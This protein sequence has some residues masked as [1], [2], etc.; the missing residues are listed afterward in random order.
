MG[1]GK[2]I[3][4]VL[5]AP[6]ETRNLKYEV[7]NTNS[8]F[9]QDFEIITDGSPGMFPDWQKGEYQGGMGIPAAWRLA[10][11][12]ANQLGRTPWHSFRAVA[13]KPPEKIEPQPTLLAYPAGSEEPAL[14][15]W[16]SA[17]LDRMWHGNAIGIIAARSPLGYP[18][19]AL[20]VGA[21]SVVV[22]RFG[23]D[24]VTGYNPPPPG[25]RPGE[26]GYLI[27]GRWYHADE[28][29][30]WCG[31]KKPGQLRGMGVLENHFQALSRSQALDSAASAVSSAGVPTGLLESLNPDLTQAEA[32]KLKAAW[33]AAQRTR[34]V[35]VLNPSTHFTPIAWNP[36]ETQLLESRQYSITDWA[37]IFG[38]P[39]SYAGGQNASRVYANIVDQGMD[40]LRYG[41]VGDM[42]AEFEALM[43][44]LLPRGQYVK[45]N[46]DHLLRADTKG[47]YEA[48]AIALAAKFLTADEVRELEEKPPLTDEQKKAI[49]EAA[50]PPPAPGQGAAGPQPARPTAASNSA[51]S[52]TA[53]PR[54][55]AVR[56]VGLVG[57]LL[58]AREWDLALAVMEEVRDFR[59][60]QVRTVD[61]T[62]W[63]LRGYPEFNQH[64]PRWPR[65]T[66]KH[67]G[68]WTDSPGGR[69]PFGAKGAG[70][71][72]KGQWTSWENGV[73]SFGGGTTNEAEITATGK[74]VLKTK[75]MSGTKK[76]KAEAEFDA[77]VDEMDANPV[78]AAAK[79][80]K[81]QTVAEAD[82]AFDA[83]T[84]AEKAAA[85][86]ELDDFLADIQAAVD[87][88]TAPDTNTVPKDQAEV[89]AIAASLDVPKP[90]YSKT[91]DWDGDQWAAYWQASVEGDSIS[92]AVKAANAAGGSQAGQFAPAA[93]PLATV[94]PNAS[95]VA[96]PAQ[97]AADPPPVPDLKPKAAPGTPWMESQW[98]DFFTDDGEGPPMLPDF[99]PDGKAQLDLIADQLGVQPPPMGVGSKS[100]SGEQWQTYWKESTYGLKPQ[101]AAAKA[102]GAA[103]AP[104]VGKLDAAPNDPATAKA[105]IDAL[106]AE[107]GKGPGGAPLGDG[108]LPGASPNLLGANAP[109]VSLG[110]GS[111]LDTGQKFG[112]FAVGGPLV[113]I[114]PTPYGSPSSKANKIAKQYAAALGGKVPKWEATAARNYSGSDYLSMNQALWTDNFDGAPDHT[115][116]QITNLTNLIN[117]YQTPETITAVRGLTADPS[118]PDPPATGKTYASKGFQ[119][120]SVGAGA[121]THKGTVLKITIPKGTNAAV[122]NGGGLSH[123][124][125]EEELVLPHNTRYAVTADYM[126]G[127][128]RWLEVTALPPE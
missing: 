120:T 127:G 97:V 107:L 49:A 13:G 92:G 125:H 59:A 81:P 33:T 96:A 62:A 58:D 24:P 60:W 42:V 11:L 18:T 20:W 47:R 128:K 75:P 102:N 103:V 67:A 55:A 44:G 29:I 52:G 123:F 91:L 27:G 90:P 45:G 63:Q 82:A 118:I 2:I 72:S 31:P 87:K 21:E 79:V 30:H 38:L 50:A 16:R 7:T 106:W 86:A 109:G 89:D 68:E 46:L 98:E 100:W 41:L 99:P 9:R 119:S 12:V 84:P 83:M 76:S 113:P 77:F 1:L 104:T 22:D 39:S 64:Q 34:S 126:K 57:R 65:G 121:F 95:N 4:R 14:N 53:R 122:M 36:T 5:G 117:R 26:R 32:D 108:G 28:I 85:E 17:A 105:Q 3:S 10:L 8:G 48:H 6:E 15:V 54:L 61:M 71:W 70:T 111:T 19:S 51:G 40:I 35:A 114:K 43:T 74:A 115:K 94:A 88:A 23:S 69:A 116:A 110:D 37:N 56:A 25:F 93:P 66:G 78:K 73:H 112:S 80:K 124:P 101:A